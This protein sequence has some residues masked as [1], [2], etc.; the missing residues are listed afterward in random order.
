M[1]K[2][3]MAISVTVAAVAVLAVAIGYQSNAITK[4]GTTA[5]QTGGDSG[6][7]ATQNNSAA[8]HSK[9]ALSSLISTG[10]PL[11]GDQKAPI[12]IVEFG[13]FQCPNCG[14]FA[15]NTEPQLEKDYFA[16]GKVNMVF[17]NVPIRGEDSVTA[18]MGA[19]CAGDQ[20]KFWEFH[21]ALYYNQGTENSGWASADNM[22]KFA[23]ELSLDRTKFDS[24]LDSGKY[25]SFVDNDFEF[26]RELGVTG[27][28]SFVVVKSDGTH[29]EEILGAQPF[30]SF[31]AVLDKKLSSES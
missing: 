9:L 15:R 28:P 1:I 12:T 25:K 11:R 6:I 7:V 30:S 21:D 2:K 29:P 20:G 13:D 8:S 31:K 23:S 3:F 17:K 16:T 19:Q 24:C 22:K 4:N 5:E 14:R 26:A 18:S 27:T 10:S